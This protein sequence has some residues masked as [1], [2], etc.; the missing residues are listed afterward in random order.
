MNYGNFSLSP[1]LDIIAAMVKE[2]VMS[3]IYPIGSIYISINNKN[4]FELFGIGTWEKIEDRFLLAASDTYN[5]GTIGG[6]SEHTLTLDEIP[7]HTHAT[8]SGS[9]PTSTET[10]NTKWGFQDC[11]LYTEA[12]K[13]LRYIGTLSDEGGGNAHNNM[14][15]YLAVYMWKRV[16]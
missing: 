14:P 13:S 11:I 8:R 1:Q 16:A 9:N 2:S 3:T 7:T 12:E 5:G 15:P 4:P 10:P 6:E